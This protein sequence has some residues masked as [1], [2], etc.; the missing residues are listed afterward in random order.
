MTTSITT[1][2]NR[3]SSDPQFAN[4]IAHTE[5]I[6]ARDAAYADLDSPLGAV[7]HDVL[8]S[9]GISRFYTHQAQAVNR[10]R[11]GANVIVSTATASGKSLCYHIPVLDTL[12]QDP[13]ARA[14]YVFPTKALAQDQLGSV[15]GMIPAHSNICSRQ[16]CHHRW[17]APFDLPHPRCPQCGADKVTRPAGEQ[18]AIRAGLPY[19]LPKDPGMDANDVHQQ[20][21][22]DVL[23]NAILD[24][25]N[26]NL[27][28]RVYAKPAS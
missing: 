1:F 18:A 21:G 15:R 26:Q 19:W 11:E 5:R 12:S 20:H 17:D 16:A 24:L 9:L 13:G 23:A 28:G 4:P 6:P 14:L 10:L 8:D 2:L 25:F 22:L 27:P 7:A 3:L